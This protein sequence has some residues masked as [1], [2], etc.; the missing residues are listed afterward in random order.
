MGVKNPGLLAKIK[1]SLQRRGLLG[2]IRAAVGYYPNMLRETRHRRAIEEIN[3]RFDRECGIDTAGS[4]PGGKIV[5]DKASAEHATAYQPILPEPFAEVMK[6][7]PID[8]GKCV[9]VDFG[10]GKGRAVLLASEFPFKKVVGVEFSSQLH[11]IATSNCK[12]Y[13][14]KTQACKTIEL[15][16]ID[17]MEYEI[18]SEPAVFFFYNPFREEVMTEVVRRIDRSLRERPRKAFVVYFWPEVARLWDD[19]DNLETFPI[20]S[21]QW[22]GGRSLPCV[23]VWATKGSLE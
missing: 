9:F 19:T 20:R 18:P 11:E 10:S 17:A 12:K 13:R 16:C 4:V 5:T 3:R 1:R 15:L 7:L 14:S 22:P 2:T 21:P 23:K 8:F 6:Q